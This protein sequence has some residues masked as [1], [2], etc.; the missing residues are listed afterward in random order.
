MADVLNMVDR[1]VAAVCVASGTTST[2]RGK[3]SGQT[4][5]DADGLHT[6]DEVVEAVR[7]REGERW[8]RKEMSSLGG[9]S[10]WAYIS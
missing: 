4:G 7:A 6:A 8:T 5:Q 9:R 10:P 3:H 1:T 2:G